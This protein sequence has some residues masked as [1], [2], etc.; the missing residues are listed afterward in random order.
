MEK[1]R[2]LKFFEHIPAT[3]DKGM[4]LTRLGYKKTTTVMDDDYRKNLME[5][6]SK[7]L[8]LC[9]TKGVFGTFNIIN[10]DEESVE[11]E[12]GVTLK[13]RSLSKLLS[14]S[15]D[16]VLMASTVGKDIVDRIVDEIKNKDAAFGVILDAVA[17][18]TADA[19]LDWMVD[20]IN[21]MIRRE[22]KKLT[23]M[24]YSPGYGDLPLSNQ[25][26]I[27]DVLNL[28][29][30]G[31]NITERFMLVPEK[32]VIAIAGVEGVGYNE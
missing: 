14:N 7:G 17:S 22:G 30:L 26:L 11:L 23:G 9:N 20:F 25:K 32:S 1:Y 31:I 4:I 2:G 19:A 18:E 29:R 6:I 10:R 12:N 15:M 3:P 13:S 28:E 5:N 21:K 27:F 8:M 24:R 16:V